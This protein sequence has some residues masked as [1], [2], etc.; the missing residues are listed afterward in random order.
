MT[1]D[2]RRI[3][4][5]LKFPNLGRVSIGRATLES[6]N[7]PEVDKQYL[8][9]KYQGS[10]PPGLFWFLCDARVCELLGVK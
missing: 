2:Q 1:A 7:L 4:K 9:A 6:M 10:D 3:S 8:R 5:P